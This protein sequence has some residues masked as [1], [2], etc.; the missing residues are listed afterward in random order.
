MA[1]LK[2]LPLFFALPIHARLALAASLLGL[3]TSCVSFLFPAFPSAILCFYFPLCWILWVIS[4]FLG[5]GRNLGFLVI[6]WNI[7]NLSILVM[8]C[9]LIF[10]AGDVSNS[11]GTELIWFFSY[12]P[13]IIP[14]GFVLGPFIGALESSSKV[15]EMLFGH[16]L[17][18]IIGDWATFSVVAAVQS[19]LL[20]ICAIVFVGSRPSPPHAG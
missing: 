7:I 11:Q 1:T 4:T 19:I 13:V 2:L 17:G 12:L 16:A 9:S 8:F 14:I 3:S 5:A 18:G 15:F 6:T 20:V 10:S